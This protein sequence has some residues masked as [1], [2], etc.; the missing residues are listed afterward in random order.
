MSFSPRS[1]KPQLQRNP[2]AGRHRSYNSYRTYRPQEGNS[3]NPGGLDIQPGV[4]IRGPAQPRARP[5]RERPRPCGSCALRRTDSRAAG[6]SLSLPLRIP[7]ASPSVRAQ[8]CCSHFHLVHGRKQ[9]LA[10]RRMPGTLGCSLFSRSNSAARR[11]SCS[12]GVTAGSFR[13]L[14]VGIEGLWS[15]PPAGPPLGRPIAADFCR[16]AL[17]FRRR[18]PAI[19]HSAMPC[20]GVLL[21]FAHDSVHFVGE[22]WRG[23][24]GLDPPCDYGA[25]PANRM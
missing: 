16:N 12:S 21:L 18:G 22:L 24:P 17:D 15:F 4:A 10:S 11:S 23:S 1:A 9:L 25:R 6:C 7:Q 19:D 2:R 8:P 20:R 13:V 5:R 14:L 3:A